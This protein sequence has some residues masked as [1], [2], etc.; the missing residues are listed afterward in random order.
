MTGSGM[1]E[2]MWHELRSM[3]IFSNSIY[4]VNKKIHYVLR[5][6]LSDYHSAITATSMECSI[7]CVISR[8][9]QFIR[10]SEQERGSRTQ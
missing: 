6:L 7:P 1:S 4:P 2:I 5:D 9:F 3:N 8:N 10:N